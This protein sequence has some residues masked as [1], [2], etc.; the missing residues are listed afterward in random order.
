MCAYMCVDTNRD[1]KR[2]LG[3]LEQVAMMCPVWVLRTKLRSSTRSACALY[4]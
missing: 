1:K 2:V 4:P 3:P